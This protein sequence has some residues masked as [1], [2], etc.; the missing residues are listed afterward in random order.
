M[1][2]EKSHMQGYALLKLFFLCF[3]L[4]KQ[5]K[6]KVIEKTILRDRYKKSNPVSWNRTNS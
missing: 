5:S 2:K 3:L 6:R 1:N 4:S